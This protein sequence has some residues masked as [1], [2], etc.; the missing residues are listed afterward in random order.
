MGVIL[1][2]RGRAVAG[3]LPS[4]RRGQIRAQTCHLEETFAR[5]RRYLTELLALLLAFIILCTLH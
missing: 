3:V 4:I 5:S 1:C 2:V